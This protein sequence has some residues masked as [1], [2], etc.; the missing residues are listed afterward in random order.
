MVYDMIP[1]LFG[2]DL[3]LRGWMDKEL[4]IAYAQ[5]YVC[6]SG[7]TR[8][9]LLSFYP[10]L[11][12]DKVTVAYCGVDERV[13]HRHDPAALAAFRQDHG[14]DRPYFLFV[15]SR[16]Q[17]RGYKNSQ[18]FFD[19]IKSLR[20]ADFDILCVG[21]EPEI[22]PAVLAGLPAGVR[23][24][25]HELSDADLGLAYGGALA[26]VYPSLYEG[27]GMPVIE[28]MAAGCPVITTRH[29][30]LAEA[31]GEAAHLL[32]G[33]SVSEMAD[34]IARVRNADYR[35]QLIRRGLEHAGQ[36]RWEGMASEFSRQ[37]DAVLAEARAGVYDSFL[38]R[39]QELRLVQA[40]VDVM[41]PCAP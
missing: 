36:F 41:P 23:C 35:E 13:F 3:N 32:S 34:A 14:L 33:F 25:R 31:A 12:P 38:S 22:E 39:W 24:M 19:A 21:G 16:V 18:L 6:I 15:G 37:V 40:D 26:L 7:T 11:D 1:E 9:D 30:S 10:E 27:F 4:A 8:K 20:N 28:A 17:H 2:F 5:R 29:G